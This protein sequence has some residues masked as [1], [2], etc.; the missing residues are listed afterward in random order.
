MLYKETTDERGR[1]VPRGYYVSQTCDSLPGVFSV[2]YELKKKK[3][4]FDGGGHSYRAS[5]TRGVGK[6]S[7]GEALGHFGT[8]LA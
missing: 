1:G 8:G 7:T 4:D 5:V 3:M 6:R 2:R